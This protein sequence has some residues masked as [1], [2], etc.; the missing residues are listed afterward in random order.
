MNRILKSSILGLL[1]ATALAVTAS[2]ADKVRVAFVPQIQGIPYYVAMEEGAKKAAAAF[3]VEYIQQGP[4]S[5]NSA[6]Q[7]RIFESFVSQGVNVVGV[8]PV[9]V[10]TLKPAIASARA[11]NIHVITSDADAVGSE[12]EFYVAQAMDQDLGFTILDEM[13][14]RIGAEGKIAIISDAPTIASLNAWI[15]AIKERATTKYPKLQ[16]VSVDHTDGTASRAFQFAT[17]AMTRTPDLGGIIGI[18]S[19]TCPGIGQAVEAAGKQGQIVTAGFCS[20]NTVKDYVMSGAMTY[21]VLWN[22]ADLGYLTVW[23]GKQ[24][25]DGVAFEESPKIEGLDAKVRWLKDEKILLLGDPMVFTKENIA[26]FN[27]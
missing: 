26:Q 24:V 4:T 20:P 15:A 1:A 2:A 22:P 3:G 9:D 10:E 21:S 27:F 11:K 5:T 12:R 8:S 7:L 19:T 13:V 6:D 16:I 25:A 23:A 17:D 18:A 14:E